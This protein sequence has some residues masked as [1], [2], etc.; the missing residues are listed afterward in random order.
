MK[1]AIFHNYMDN[2]G[3]AEKVSLI[4]GR[5]LGADIY[6]TVADH[7][8]IK[9]M[10]FGTRVKTLGWLPIN[11]P[12]RQQIALW[13]FRRLNLSRFYDHFIIGGDWAV[14]AAVKNKPN[15]WYV[16]SPIREIWDLYSYVRRT[17]TPP[18]SRPVF[19]M[20]VRL[21]RHLNLKYLKHVG[22]LVCNSQN[23]RGR[24]KRYLKR[25]AT[26][27]HP[28]VET[29]KFH[30]GE[31][32]D[33]W[34]SVNRLITFKRIEMQMDAFRRMPD[35]KLI[36]VGSYEKNIAYQQYRKYIESIKPKNVKLLSWVSQEKLI[37]LYANCRGFITTARNEDFG[38]TPLEA[39]AS[40]KPVVCGNE[41]G[42]K[43]TVINGLTGMLID[44]I[45]EDKII[46][47][48]REVGG[49]PE[50][51]RKECLK[52]ARNFDTRIFV[53]EIKEVL[54]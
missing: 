42:Y 20:W 2:I 51:F 43:E 21:N 26:V 46:H 24:V 45:N 14:S 52:R 28:P 32:G 5:E 4:M 13:K 47:A 17:Q 31:S 36:I 40:G 38:L 37:D 3:G 10:G 44:D 49:K 19:D 35:E 29:G 7:D 25:D 27:I 15:L 50:S 33:Y 48:V 11:A 16:H 39:M 8:M 53:R 23:T 30:C 22:K 1:T 18:L 9:K 12:Y 54:R 6:S 34:L 41:G